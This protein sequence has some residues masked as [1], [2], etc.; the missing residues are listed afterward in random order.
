MK[1]NLT[2]LYNT[3]V[4][5]VKIKEEYTE[6]FE[7]VKKNSDT[8]EDFKNR[9]IKEKRDELTNKVESNLR[10]FYQYLDKLKKEIAI[11]TQETSYKANIESQELNNMLMIIYSC[12]GNLSREHMEFIINRYKDDIKTLKFL[13]NIFISQNILYPTNMDEQI[14]VLDDLDLAFRQLDDSI[15]S[16]FTS[17]T[18]SSDIAAL[19]KNINIIIGH[20]DNVLETPKEEHIPRFGQPVS[21]YEFNINY[22][23]ISS[24]WYN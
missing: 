7:K 17:T 2:D 13:K 23:I 8:S 9:V 19:V 20:I 18:N 6:Y 24:R 1:Y 14:T 16:A 22:S 21:Q 3:L 15:Y 5:Q 10:L 11:Y 4:A 12:G